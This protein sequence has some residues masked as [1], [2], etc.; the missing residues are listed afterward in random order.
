LAG[1]LTA[2]YF[3]L[4]ARAGTG[5]D[6]FPF[7]GMSADARSESMADA[8]GA[9]SDDAV[10]SLSNPAALGGFR[11]REAQMSYASLPSDMS[12]GALA[13]AQPLKKGAVSLH[14]RSLQYGDIA[15]YDV[16]GNPAG[17]FAAHDALLAVAW[18]RAVGRR[19]DAGCALKQV[20]QRIAGK[21]ASS[22][23]VDGGILY[24]PGSGSISW[25]AGFRNVGGKATFLREKTSLPRT[26]F[27]A[28]SMKLFSDGWVSAIELRRLSYGKASIHIGQELWLDNAF[29]LR[30]G[31]RSDRDVGTGLSAG[32]GVKRK[33]VRLDYS[34]TIMGDV[35]GASH[36]FSLGFRFGRAGERDYQEGLSL[37]QEGRTAEAILKFKTALDADPSNKPAVRALREAVDALEKDRSGK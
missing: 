17:S 11:N 37:A 19:L 34:Y 31:W 20:S 22:T 21:S 13:Y 32:F 25:A 5:K 28:S 7:L 4:P 1:F 14:A 16:S 2:L 23:A 15:R 10:S 26:L 30:V 27:A 8:G 33:S 6:G 36:R 29:A 18:G 3:T 9:L 24:R 35:F 12:W